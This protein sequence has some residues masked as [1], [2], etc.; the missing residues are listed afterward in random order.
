MTYTGWKIEHDD[1]VESIFNKLE[2]L[3]YTKEQI[4][5]YFQ[6]ENM[7]EKEPTF[8][9]LYADRKKCH[10][11]EDLNCL[12][13]AC[14]YF[15]F[16]DDGLRVLNGDKMLMSDC[17]INSKFKDEFEYEDKIHC[18]CTNCFVPHS[19]GFA[20]KGIVDRVEDK[21]KTND[22]ITDSYSFLEYIRSYQLGEVLGKY[23]LF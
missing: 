9:L 7:V 15:K 1:K 6:F 5:D 22:S 12:Y 4:I 23:K 2:K 14:P 21:N 10:P 16:K 13:C 3:N 19:K 20:M 18:D 8:C 17:T 11:I